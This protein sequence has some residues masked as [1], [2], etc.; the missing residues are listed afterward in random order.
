[1]LKSRIDEILAAARLDL[2][3]KVYPEITG[4]DPIL[5]TGFPVGEVAATAL[6]LTGSMAEDIWFRRK[7]EHQKI[8]VNVRHAAATLNGIG[9]QKLP[10]YKLTVPMSSTYTVGFYKTADNRWIHL[11]GGLPH[12]A[13]GLVDLLKCDDN[14]KSIKLAVNE[15]NGADLEEKIAERELCGVLARSSDEWAN[16]PQG[17]ALKN[18]P[19]VTLSKI[20]DSE[21]IPLTGGKNPLEGIRILD[22]TRILAGP[23]CSRTLASYGAEVMRIASPNLPSMEPLVIETSH[24]KKSAFIDLDTSEGVKTLTDMI[25]DA[26][27]FVNGYRT[28]ALEARGFGP[29]E[30]AQIRPG[31]IYVNI[32]CYG[33][34]GPWVSRKGWEQL[35]QTTTGIAYEQRT[36]SGKPQL[37]PAAPNDYTTGYLAAYGTLLAIVNRMEQGGSWHVKASL[38]QTGMWL[39]RLGATMDMTKAT[40]L[41]NLENCM[42]QVK[43][44][45]GPLFHLKPAV[46]LSKTSPKWTKPPVPLGFHKPK[47]EN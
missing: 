11:V 18:L 44:E 27:V 13:Q 15:W 38:C 21:P 45:W 37:I 46:K 28:G 30:L 17:K 16:H 8:K 25:K 14:R 26:D 5:S 39:T 40:G 33:S 41:S 35:A 43:T 31:I 29:N 6:G 24:G 1:M 23:N 47:W 10:D 20:A 7:G 19:A 22:L 12:L 36:K 9:I 3:E 32:N 42:T 2:S 34:V 4:N